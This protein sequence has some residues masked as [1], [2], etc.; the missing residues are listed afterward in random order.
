MAYFGITRGEN[1][2]VQNGYVFK[3]GTCLTFSKMVLE[4]IVLELRTDRLTRHRIDGGTIHV[5]V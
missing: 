3:K 5:T 4:R 2:T 1:E